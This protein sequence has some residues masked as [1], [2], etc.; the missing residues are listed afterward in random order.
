MGVKLLPT[1][2]P[3]HQ[4]LC[5]PGMEYRW[6][7]MWQW[8]PGLEGLFAESWLFAWCIWKKSFQVLP[9]WVYWNVKNQLFVLIFEGG[10]IWK[11][12]KKT[13]R[14]KSEKPGRNQAEIR[15]QE[16]PRPCAWEPLTF[17]FTHTEISEFLPLLM[18]SVPRFSLLCARCGFSRL[19]E[20]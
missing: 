14:E 17:C 20:L 3:K 1:A 10:R 5:L 15:T 18:W 11:W 12:E 2:F 4:E 19:L 13:E 7:I 6:M 16:C 8:T 9:I